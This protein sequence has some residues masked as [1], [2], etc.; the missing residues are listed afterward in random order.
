MNKKRKHIELFAGCGGMA[1]GM[2]SAGY[3]LIFANEVS[4]MAANT[5][6]KNLLKSNLENPSEKVKW[7]HSRFGL[8]QYTNRLR[9][10]LL[11]HGE[12]ENCEL[13]PNQLGG[14]KDQLLIGDVRLLNS[15]LKEHNIQDPYN[16]ELDLISGGPPCQSFS[17]AGKRELHN[18]KNRLPLDFAEIC[19]RLNPKVVLLENVKGILSAFSDY[20]EK[21]YAW[22]EVAK[23]FALKGYAPICMLINSKYFG[24]AQNRPRYIMV[25]LRN[26]VFSKLRVVHSN[27]PILEKINTFCEKA[28]SDYSR[29]T[30]GDLDYYNIEKTPALFDGKILPMPTT[31]GKESWISVKEAIND[32]SPSGSNKISNYVYELN[33][34]LGDNKTNGKIQNHN[35]RRHTLKVQKRFLFL[36]LL[37]HAGDFRDELIRSKRFGVSLASSTIKQLYKSLSTK[38]DQFNDLFPTTS[39]LADFI[40]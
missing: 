21:H 38:I 27:N 20:G 15:L 39:Q 33:S 8:E 14:L 35:Q 7:L 6:A 34:L 36:Q 17:L 9:E 23:A 40:L 25:A 37:N 26:D 32:L 22:F 2:K 13:D 29:L 19:E 10:N 4:P 24:I 31:F 1:V 18:Y 3:D 30:L 5:F 16:G 12:I 28:C 11:T